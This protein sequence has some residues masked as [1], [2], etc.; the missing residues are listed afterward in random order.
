MKLFLSY[1]SADSRI[2]EDVHLALVGAGHDVFFDR[3]SLLPG[4]NFEKQIRKDFDAADGLIFLISSNSVRQG[5]YARTELKYAQE[6]W[7]HPERRVLPVM[8]EP[9]RFEEIPAYLRAVTI[10]QPEGNTAAEV[11]DT[12]RKWHGTD[13]AETKSANLFTYLIRWLVL[14]LSGILLAVLFGTLFSYL[15]P[16][17]NIDSSLASLFLLTGMVTALAIRGLWHA[18]L[19][20]IKWKG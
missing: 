20:R 3:P 4:D 12:L 8:V 14:L 11:V 16:R 5:S 19:Q 7:A 1:A 18:M 9:T 6:K 2:A 15:Y 17:V 10:L 13:K